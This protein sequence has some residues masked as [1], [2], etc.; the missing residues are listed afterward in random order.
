MNYNKMD[1]N[2]PSIAIVGGGIAGT[3]SAIHFSELGF[4]VTILEKGP[5]LVNGP[6]ICH[7][8]AGGNLYRDI[9]VEQCVKLLTQSIDT[10]RLFPHTINIRPTIIAVPHSDGGDPLA[11]L[12]RLKVIQNSYAE[13]VKQDAS[14]QV[15]GDP[16]QYYK[17]YSQQD[18]LALAKRTQPLNPTS[19]DDWCIPFAKHTDLDT[20]KFP[21][22][23]VQEYGWS[24]FRLS[25]TAQLSLGK[26]P[27]CTVL[28]NSRLQSAQSTDQGWSLTYTDSENQSRHLKAD[29]L[30][31]ASGF[32]TGIV[33]DFVGSKQQRLVEFKAAYVTEWAYSQAC[34]EEWP[35]V[36]FHGP[37]GT[38][39]GMAQL[40][41]YA[42]GVFQ[43][44][45]MTEG[46]TL[47]E[48]GLVSSS[49]DSSQPQLPSKLLKK[50]VSGWSEAQL[51]LRTRAA[52][53]H[54]SQFIPSFGSA[55]VGGK[56]LFGAQQIPG[57][58]PSLRA[59]DVSFCGDRYARLEV[60]KASSTFE[61]AQKIAQHWFDT[62]D[63]VSIED[64]HTVTMSLNLRE[65]EDRAIGLT[66]ERGYP[67]SLAKVSGQEH[68]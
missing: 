2:Q 61:A 23:V 25:A 12:P 10:V 8:H 16:Q 50:I 27:N 42:D 30:I 20:L 60:V 29:Y 26:Q 56:P 52:I 62:S 36:I 65:I 49:T 34:Q 32:E 59:A 66:Q 9:S 15:L 22:V 28:T 47:F 18:L 6:P 37:R 39:Q 4:K 33:D 13:L 31:N 5:S 46:I 43:L 38:P 64:S 41:P 53:T 21:V 7:L 67:D 63:S 11:L 54:M 3:T 14:N 68:S 51:D 58:D 57:T 45:G 17:L 55:V 1:T 24:V 48:G 35:E 44:H 19:L 40:T